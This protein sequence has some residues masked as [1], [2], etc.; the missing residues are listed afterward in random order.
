MLQLGTFHFQT[1]YLF[2]TAWK[3]TEVELVKE[4]AA[5][6]VSAQRIGVRIGRTTK[7]VRRL[8]VELGI[9]VKSQAD[10][11]ASMGLT[12]RWHPERPLHDRRSPSESSAVRPRTYR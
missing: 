3:P 5:K 8:A 11:R 7:S 2:M 9:S 12:A 6:G 1:A 4:L 10:L